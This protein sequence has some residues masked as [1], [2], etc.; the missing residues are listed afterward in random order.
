MTQTLPSHTA[1][2]RIAVLLAGLLSITACVS[3]QLAP[4]ESLQAAEM[5]INN[6]EQSGVADYA[7]AELSAAREKLTDARTAVRNEEMDSALQLADQA[8]ADAELATAN[9]ELAKAKEINNDMLK[10]IT[11]LKQEMQRNTGGVSQ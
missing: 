10:S 5:A 7:S 1:H 3:T 8:R 9:A 4:T 6:A 11:T 2:M